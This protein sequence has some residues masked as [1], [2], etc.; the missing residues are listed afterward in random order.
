MKK[1]LICP[2]KKCGNNINFLNSNFCSHCGTR[3]VIFI[4]KCVCGEERFPDERYCPKCG[5]KK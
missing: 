4:D 2:N 1:K 3:T 5:I